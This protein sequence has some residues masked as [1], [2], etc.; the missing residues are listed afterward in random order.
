M[1]MSVAVVLVV[2]F[3]LLF[4]ITLLFPGLP[5]GDMIFDLLPDFF[6]ISEINYSILGISGKTLVNGVLNGVFWGLFIALIYGLGRRASKREVILPMSI[7]SPSAPSSLPVLWLPKPPARG[8]P[9]KVRKIETYVPL[10][11]NIETI[12]GIGR[13]YGSRLRVSGVKVVGDLLRVGSTSKGRRDLAYKIG[14]APTTM[15]KWVN[16]ADFYRI[17]GIGKQYADLLNVAGVNTVIDLSERHPMNLYEK[18]RE[19]NIG[20][21]LVRRAPPYRKI[22]GWIKSAKE[23]IRIVE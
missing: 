8:P 1:E 4:G 22:E 18:L 17:R 19:T 6:G 23:L 3:L 13:I 16:Q 2:A 5:P 21:N 12:E 11:Q 14:V 20:R 10:D 15:L 9:P 7:P